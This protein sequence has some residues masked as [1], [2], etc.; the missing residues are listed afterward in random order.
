MKRSFAV[1]I[2]V[3][4][5]AAGCGGSNTA[6]SSDSASNAQQN[7]TTPANQTPEQV[8]AR[9]IEQMMQQGGVVS[10][11][12]AVNYEQ[13]TALIPDVAGWEKSDVKGSQGSMAGI[14]FAR[15]EAQYEKGDTSINLEITDTAMIQ[16]M[17][18]PFQMVASGGFDQKSTEGYKRGTKVAGHP[19]WEEWENQSKSAEVNIL[20][21]NRFIVRGSGDDLPNSDVVKQ[22][23]EAINLSKLATLK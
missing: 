12:K 1:G 22:V 5:L 13:L 14:S 21:G 19:G 15:A 6:N 16:M 11:A 7:S 23:I 17:V 20:V 4:G 10:Q 3:A 9:G 2:L 18:M 8:A